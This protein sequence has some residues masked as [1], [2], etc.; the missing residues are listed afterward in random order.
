MPYFARGWIYTS[1]YSRDIMM[2]NAQLDGTELERFRGRFI[3]T[4]ANLSCFMC[5]SQYKAHCDECLVA[6]NIYKQPS[7]KVTGIVEPQQTIG[8]ATICIPFMEI[9][10]LLDVK[11]QIGYAKVP[12][13]LSMIDM[14]D[15]G[16]E[17]SFQDQVVKYGNT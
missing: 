7:K 14:V 2:M 1:Y 17:I 9:D 4:V 16:L 8:A 11:F 10:H 6:A 13:L 12:T 15:N 5:L 3:D